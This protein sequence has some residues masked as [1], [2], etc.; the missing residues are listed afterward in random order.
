MTQEIT[1]IQEN[2]NLKKAILFILLI[3]FITKLFS[4]EIILELQDQYLSFGEWTTLKVTTTGD[5]SRPKFNEEENIE[6]VYSGSSSSFSNINGKTSQSKTYI[7][8]VVPQEEGELELPIFYSKN[9]K[10]EKIISNNL[11]LYVEKNNSSTAN[12]FNTETNSGTDFTMLFIDLP[13]REIYSGEAVEVTIRAYFNQK[14]SHN[15]LKNPYIEK[16]S[17]TLDL[18]GNFKQNT[19]V[20][21]NDKPWI[22]AKWKGY[23]TSIGN[24]SNNLQL[25]MDSVVNI[26]SESGFFFSRTEQKEITTESDL[27]P[28]N[29]LSLPEENKPVNFSGAI[30]NFSISSRI[31]SN[32]VK[33]GDPISLIIDI[34][35]KGNFKRVTEPTSLDKNGW[36]FYPPSSSYSGND[37][38][39][40]QGVKTFQNILIP[41][42]TKID[43]TPIFTFSYFNPLEK[44][45]V[46]LKTTEKDIKVDEGIQYIERNKAIKHVEFKDLGTILKHVQSPVITKELVIKSKNISVILFAISILFLITFFILFYLFRFGPPKQLVIKAEL[47]KIQKQV[48]IYEDSKSYNEALNELFSIVKNKNIISNLSNNSITAN[49]VKNNDALFHL[50]HTLEEIKYMNKVIDNNEYNKIKESVIKELV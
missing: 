35:G 30:G 33:T 27:Y 4:Q 31:D 19:G 48:A 17:F 12:L 41:R 45:Y 44:K 46:T 11:I 25:K 14:Y 36:K 42:N 23:L 40:Y 34:F 15:I 43:K 2:G 32:E 3:T 18:V 9:S 10:N 24:G 38:S 1:L 50:V 13:D 47:L 28:L 20:L 6:L 22:E 21:I 16:G 37:N 7:Y 39:D 29:I 8:K 5:L 26:Q 49:D